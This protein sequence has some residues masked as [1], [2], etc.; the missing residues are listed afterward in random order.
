M[1]IIDESAVKSYDIRGIYPDQVDEEFAWLLGAALPRVLSAGNVAIAHDARL[2]SPALYAALADGFRHA[3]STVKGLGQ[4]PTELLY[5]VM[6]SGLEFDLGVMITASH[7]PPDYNGFKVVKQ[8][9]EPVTGATGLTDA[10]E[11]MKQMEADLPATPEPPPEMPS[12]AADYMDFALDLVGRPEPGKPELVVDA[13]NGMGGCL[14]EQITDRLGLEPRRLNFE[15]DGRFPA[16]H[17]DPTRMENLQ[18]LIDTVGERGAKLGFSYDGDAD[19]VV[20]VLEDGHVVDGSEMSAC[21][22]RRLLERD[23]GCVFGL[24]QTTSRKVWGYFRKQGVEPVMVP[25]GHAKIKRVLRGEPRMAFAGEHAGHYYYRDFFCCDSALITTL[26]LLHLVGDGLS[27]LVDEFRGRW[28]RSPGGTSVEFDR[29]DVALEVCRRAALEVLEDAPKPL[30]ITCEREGKVLRNCSADDFETAD[31]VRI[32]YPDWWFCV[33]PSGTEPI[34]RVVV[35]CT[36]RDAVEG[37]TQ[38]LLRLFERA[39]GA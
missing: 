37:R 26:H 30:E 16:H 27:S 34:A 31:S 28:H 21:I 32:D 7:N 4:C 36:D 19:R 39:K 5:Y 22:A 17:P 14:W 18:P 10:C 35:E 3:G 9:G 25:V 8:G 1:A 29:Q 23:P 6:G 15:P 24:G 20:V 38:R 2:S 11:L 13:G 12:P 33:R